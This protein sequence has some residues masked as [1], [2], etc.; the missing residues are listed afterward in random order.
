M[1]LTS[2]RQLIYSAGVLLL[3]ASLRLWHISQTPPGLYLDEAYHLL[4]AQEIAYGE[5]LPVFITGN[6]G[7]EPLFVY[8]AVIPLKILGPVAWAGRLATVWA[9][10]VG[11]A[12][13]MRAGRELFPGRSVGVLAGLVLATL[14]WSLTFSRFGSQPIL[15]VPAA[16]GTLAGL[17]HGARTDTRRAFIVAG[18]SLGLGFVHLIGLPKADGSV[19]YAHH[20]S[21]P[22]AD[23]YP[24]WQWHPGELVVETYSLSLPADMSPGDYIWQ[25]GWYDEGTSGPGARLPAR[26]ETGQSLGDVAPLETVHIGAP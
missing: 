8:L 7:Y 5:A 22:C 20:D 25:T 13:T 4:R 9:G 19:L 1:S 17:W 23:T 21:Q 18:V 15:A 24:A 14:L 3:A 16:A 6:N 10:L 12:L 26:D 2:R 11:V